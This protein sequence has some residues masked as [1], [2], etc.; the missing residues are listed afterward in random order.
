MKCFE[1]NGKT[2]KI[3]T[4]KVFSGNILIENIT[5]FKCKKCGELFFDEAS[6]NN[7]LKKVKEIKQKI[8]AMV[9]SKI[10]VVM[11]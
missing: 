9:L 6:Y 4:S 2:E 11:I 10:K 7:T 5:A 3:K 8:P 1:C